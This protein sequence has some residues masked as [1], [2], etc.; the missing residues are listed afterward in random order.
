VS[1]SR[2][3]PFRSRVDAQADRSRGGLGIGLTLARQLVEMHGGTVDAHS[4]GPVRGS[5]FIVRLPVAERS[6]MP[7]TAQ[8]QA[9]SSQ[10]EDRE[11]LREARFDWQ[12]TSPAM[13]A[14]KGAMDRPRRPTRDDRQVGRTEAGR[15]AIG[16]SPS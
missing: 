9:G 3:E 5:E 14:G 15:A 8:A 12:V 1:P 6:P 4:D 7:A 13:S 2:A 16:K 10:E 11:R